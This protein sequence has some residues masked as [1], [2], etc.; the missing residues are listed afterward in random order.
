MTIRQDVDIIIISNAQDDSLQNTT[1]Q[2]VNSLKNS[3]DPDDFD[4][5]IIVI[6]SER[7]LE[8]FQYPGTL[9]IYPDTTF[10]YNKYL[11]IGIKMTK[12]N[13]V[14]LCNNDLIFH[15]KWATH[16]VKCFDIYS[17][18]VS[19][20]P[21][22][23]THHTNLGYSIGQEV[24][25]GYRIREEIA[26]WCI[27]V[28][29]EAFNRMGMLDENYKFWY[30]DNDY[31]NT[32]FA[33]DMPHLLV[34]SSVVDHLESITLNRQPEKLQIELTENTFNYYS[35]KWISKLGSTWHLL[36]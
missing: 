1:I 23:S 12:S 6:E 28:K 31:A 11:N 2:A 32:L 21:M 27:F 5:H 3:E 24:R 34:C 35:K 14:C 17:N 7:S 16:L 18:L 33:L 4:F 13:Y 22:C 29:R 20:S 30:A 25:F 19:A 8:P 9:T 10:G 15:P 26:G 36:D